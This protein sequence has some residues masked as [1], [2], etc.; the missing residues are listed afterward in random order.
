M[1]ADSVADCVPGW[2]AD[3]FADSVADCAD[4][5]AA[6]WGGC[7]R[8]LG[9]G[10]RVGGL[11]TSR[12]VCRTFGQV[13]WLDVFFHYWNRVFRLNPALW[14]DLAPFEPRRAAA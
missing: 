13:I 12:L 14:L 2:A 8:S 6:A 10:L 5:G 4:S 11:L 7:S 1:V 9:S 3:S